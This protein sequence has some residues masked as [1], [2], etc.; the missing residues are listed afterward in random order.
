MVQRLDVTGLNGKTNSYSHYNFS[1]L[2]DVLTDHPGLPNTKN[3]SVKVTEEKEYIK[4][5]TLCDEQDLDK[6]SIE[7]VE[8][9]LNF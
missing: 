5:C 2:L 7:L 3:L 4:L 8:P 1:G 9:V 6:A